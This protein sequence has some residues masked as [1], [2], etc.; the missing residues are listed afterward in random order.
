MDLWTIDGLVPDLIIESHAIPS[1]TFGRCF[2]PHGACCDA[3]SKALRYWLHY[4]LPC[5]CAMWRL[6]ATFHAS[7]LHAWL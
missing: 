5:L 1:G 4:A 7:E 6:L 2:V 3:A